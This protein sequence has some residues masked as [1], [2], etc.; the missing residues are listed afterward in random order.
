MTQNVKAPATK[1][2]LQKLYTM[3]EDESAHAIMSWTPNGESIVVHQPEAF[4]QQLLPLYFKHNNFSSFVRQLNTYGFNKVDPDAWVFGHPD[5]KQG[6]KGTLHLIQR[7]SS[8]KTA[9]AKTAAAGGD[10]ALT[11]FSPL[12]PIDP[13]ANGEGAGTPDEVALQ[14]ELALSRAEHAGIASRITELS[15]QLQLTRQ[16]QAN[17]RGSIGKIMAFLSQVYHMRGGASGQVAG[18]SSAGGAGPS[19]MPP[20]EEEEEEEGRV[21]GKRRRPAEHAGLL[22]APGPAQVAALT[23]AASDVA[24]AVAALTPRM[25]AVASAA[26]ASG[27]AP[28]L[29]SLAEERLAGVPS[30]TV[31]NRCARLQEVSS[32][33]PSVAAALPQRQRSRGQAAAE[34]LPPQLHEVAMQLVGSTE[35]QDEAIDQIKSAAADKPEPEAENLE[36]F[37]WDFLEGAQAQADNVQAPS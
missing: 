12:A 25:L 24:V 21:L 37:L 7:K 5:F 1:P 19:M 4:A 15:D 3:L 36:S 11:P 16:Q 14:H 6:A 35:L 26:A 32:S 9:A 33:E 20:M 17:T 34:A 2:F 18:P 28:P 31:D 13:G 30:L 8:H 10:A 29:P 22:D 27:L 23:A